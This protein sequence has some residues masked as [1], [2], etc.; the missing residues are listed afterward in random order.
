MHG[1]ARVPATCVSADCCI[2]AG[3]RLGPVPGTFKLGKYL[4]DRREPGPKKKVLA[5]RTSAPCCPPP[6]VRPQ[7]GV[8][9]AEWASGEPGL[10]YLSICPVEEDPKESTQ[11]ALTVSWAG[12][13]GV[14]LVKSESP[15]AVPG[16][17]TSSDR[18]LPP[19]PPPGSSATCP[20]RRSH[21]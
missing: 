13:R 15:S 11:V 16:F 20:Q 4:S 8:E 2:P 10:R 5:F 7:E 6:V 9:W 14:D 3:M 18:S 19:P 1:A 21:F 17:L 12:Q